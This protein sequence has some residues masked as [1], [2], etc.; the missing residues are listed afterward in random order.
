MQRL[1]ALHLNNQWEINPCLPTKGN[2]KVKKIS[3]YASLSC[4]AGR[5]SGMRIAGDN[6]KPAHKNTYAGSVISHTHTCASAC[7]LINCSRIACTTNT[8]MRFQPLMMTDKRE[9]TCTTPPCKRARTYKKKNK[10]QTNKKETLTHT[11]TFRF[12]YPYIS[13]YWT[14]TTYG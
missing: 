9:R 6:G 1:K 7:R 8:N 13:E 2:Y 5:L 12:T 11:H 3:D 14:H 10:K 4:V